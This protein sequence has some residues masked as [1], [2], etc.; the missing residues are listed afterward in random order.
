MKISIN[1][2]RDFIDLARL[3]QQGS[4]EELDILLTNTGLEV[5]GVES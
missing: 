3:P 5:E 2:L 1:W 4:S